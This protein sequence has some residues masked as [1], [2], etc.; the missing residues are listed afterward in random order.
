MATPV[1]PPSLNPFS[2]HKKPRKV[3]F[4]WLSWHKKDA[5]AP[6]RAEP[7]LFEG[8]DWLLPP[9]PAEPL[10]EESGEPAYPLFPE[11]SQTCRL[12]RMATSAAPIDI[13]P[14]PRFSSQSPRNQTSNL[15]SALQE[16]GATALQPSEPNV[17]TRQDA[18]R[19]SVGMRNDSITNALGSSYYGSGARP[20]YTNQRQRRESSTGSFIGNMSWGGISVGSWVRDE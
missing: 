5:A 16:A 10:F 18:G 11:S 8:D 2:Q 12:S 20:I 14:P 17:D 6:D 9:D 19:L 4:S 13:S 7:D 3:S 1:D 15:T